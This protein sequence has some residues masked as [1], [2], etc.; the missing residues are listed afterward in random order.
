MPRFLVKAVFALLVALSAPHIKAFSLAGPFEPWQTAALGYNPLGGEVAAPKNI[1]EGYRWVQPVITYGIDKSFKDY[2]GLEGVEAIDNVF[3]ILNAVPPASQI[4]EALDEY[5]LDSRRSNYRAQTLNIVDLK[6]VALAMMMEQLGLHAPE[7]WVWALRARQASSDP[8]FTN[9]LVIQRNFDPVDFEPSYFVNGTRYSYRVLEFANPNFADAVEFNIGDPGQFPVTSV[10]GAVNNIFDS[11]L[12]PGI[13]FADLTRDDVGGLRYLYSPFNYNVETPP[14]GTQIFAPNRTNLVLVTNMDLT[15][16]SARSLTSSIPEL[17]NAYPGLIIDQAIPRATNFGPVPIITTQ[18]V[19]FPFLT[20][21]TIPQIVTNIDLRLFSLQ[22]LTNPPAALLALYPN[23]VITSTNATVVAERQIAS[24]VLTNGPKE[25]WGDPFQTNLVLFTNYVTNLVLHFQYTYANVITNYF[26]PTTLVRREIFGIEKEPWSDPLNP[27]YKTNIQF[28]FETVPSG[29]IIILPPGVA[30]FEFIPGTGA[31][32]LVL[33]TNILLI[34]NFVSGG[35]LRTITDI[36]FR[37]FTNAQFAGFPIEFLPNGFLT[38]VLVTNFVTNAFVVFDVSFENVITNYSSPTTPVVTNTY[39]VSTN[40]FGPQIPITNLVSVVPGTLPIP[41]GGFLIDTNLTGFEFTGLPPIVRII[42]VTNVVSDF[43]NPATGVRTV[44]EVVYNF[45]NT[46]Y[47]V[48]PFVLT[49]ATE[50]LRPGV[51]KLTFVK[52]EPDSFLGTTW[53]YTNTYRAVVI[54]NGLR[55]TNTFRRV[56]TQPDILFMAADLGTVVNGVA[57]IRVQRNVNFVDLSDLNVT[58]PDPN[59]DRGGP[60]VIEPRGTITFNKIG[61]SIINQF[62][63]FNTEETAFLFPFVWGSFDAST[64]APIVYPESI[65]L[66][67]IEFRELSN[68]F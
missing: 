38:N 67:Q 41:S 4:L 61:P 25:P 54:T 47:W 3:E 45:T 35:L 11:P 23:L 65:I 40:L 16:L 56:Q 50:M 31:T 49:D 5:P 8:P 62:P 28:Y 22:S 68:P 32:N 21:R 43:T 52:I 66:D 53:L 17:L 1:G 18:Q 37:T 48:F 27:M 51:D 7:R 6:S 10:A 29:G 34:T 46:L 58:Q 57:P 14:A 26:S 63:G 24:I 20:N 13:F 2:F 15:L 60:G 36:E 19:I 30:G 12:A 55:R 42:Q 33:S 59:P 64:N 9:Y 39:T 44:Q